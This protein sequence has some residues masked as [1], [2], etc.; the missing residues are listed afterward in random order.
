MCLDTWPRPTSPLAMIIGLNEVKPR[1]YGL[2]NGPCGRLML[3]FLICYCFGYL[4][5]VYY[6]F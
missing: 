3:L 2:G 5:V 1:P 6:G 4:V